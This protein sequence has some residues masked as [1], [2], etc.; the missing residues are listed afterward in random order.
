MVSE[1]N[2]EH[3]NGTS[4]EPKIQLPDVA[5]ALKVRGMRVRVWVM[6][7]GSIGSECEVEG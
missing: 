2:E 5:E 7:R 4:R 3:V 1:E 6:V